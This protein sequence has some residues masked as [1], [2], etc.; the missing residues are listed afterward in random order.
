[1]F[2]KR[3]K[4]YWNYP[5]KF[6]SLDSWLVSALSTPNGG[7]SSTDLNPNTFS[8]IQ[9]QCIQA[10]SPHLADKTK[11]SKPQPKCCMYK[12]SPYQPPYCTYIWKTVNI[13][14]EWHWPPNNIYF[15]P[16]SV[17]FCQNSWN[18]SA[19]TVTVQ[20]HFFQGACS[21]LVFEARASSK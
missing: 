20:T 13:Q 9:L 17:T 4:T 19:E 18:L 15:W 1:M 6:F 12:S 7:E 5:C 3:Q 10:A 2:K 14:K 21:H 8:S 16:S 11:K